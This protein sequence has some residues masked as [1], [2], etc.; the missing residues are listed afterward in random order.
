LFDSF[1]TASRSI[2][3]AALPLA[4]A[5]ACSTL[6]AQTPVSL[7]G[8]V[9][10]APRFSELAAPLPFG[11]SILTADDIRASGRSHGTSQPA[12]PPQR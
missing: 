6:A 8:V 11:V 1:M 7:P 12:L 5:C 3:R 2:R 10:T 9:V 4:F